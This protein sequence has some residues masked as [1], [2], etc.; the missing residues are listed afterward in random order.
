ML[1]CGHLVKPANLPGTVPGTSLIPW[2][3][4]PPHPVG[5]RRGCVRHQ[6]EGVGRWDGRQMCSARERVSLVGRE[7]W[8]HC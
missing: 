1:P 6:H 8:G 3:T 4:W 7:P 2:A 5:A